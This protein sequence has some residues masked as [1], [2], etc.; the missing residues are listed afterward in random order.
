LWS[1]AET[2]RACAVTDDKQ[3][4]SAPASSTT[5]EAGL[6]AFHLTLGVGL[7]GTEADA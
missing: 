3:V 6:R 7:M 4:E 5:D 1:R 2:I